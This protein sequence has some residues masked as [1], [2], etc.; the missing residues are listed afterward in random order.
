MAFYGQRSING[1]AEWLVVPAPFCDTGV[2]WTDN[3]LV[4]G[5]LWGDGGPDETW[6]LGT[7]P[8]VCFGG[9]DVPWHCAVTFRVF[10]LPMSPENACTT[11]CR[12]RD[13]RLLNISCTPKKLAVTSW[14]I[15][16]MTTGMVR[17]INNVCVNFLLV[18]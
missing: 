8:G 4:P 13:I 7:Q 18:V 2:V 16:P 14:L 9:V 10:Y 17:L 6:A 1:S 11:A 3:L 12:V 5:A 15:I